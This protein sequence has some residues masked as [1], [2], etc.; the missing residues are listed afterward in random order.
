MRTAG[1]LQVEPT[2]S[3]VRAI[4]SPP[5]AAHLGVSNDQRRTDYPAL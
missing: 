4:I 5:R 3:A 2:R 1:F